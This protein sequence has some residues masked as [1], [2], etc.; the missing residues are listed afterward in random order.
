MPHRCLADF[1]E[2]LAADGQLAR[3]SAEVDSELEIAEITRRV[4][5]HGGPALLFEH[6]RGQSVAVV[7]NLL[8]TNGRACRALGI[9][10][11]DDIGGRIQALIE[12][13]TP[14]NWFDRL[15]MTGE[16]TGLQKFRAKLV[17]AG[18]CQ[19]V[20]RLGRDID[21]AV[22]P[23]VKAW[24]SES[25]ATITAG[26]II[27]Q[28]RAAEGAGITWCPLVAVDAQRLAVVNDGSSA[29]AHHQ[30]SY[31]AAGEKMPLVIVLGGAPAM[32][33]AAQLELP[34]GADAFQAIGLV[35]AA[36]LEIVK[37]RTHDLLVPSDADLVLEGYWDPQSEPVVLSTAAP[38]GNHYRAA[39]PLPVIQL[40]AITH[41]THPL[42]PALIEG[43]DGERQVLSLIRERTLLSAVRALAPDV[44]DLHLPL[45]G[46]TD[47]FAVASLKK[48]HPYHAR[49]VAAALWSL[50]TVGRAK[51]LI[52]VD[53]E[54]DV[55]DLQ[56]VWA[57]AGA[58]SAPERDLFWHDGPANTADHANTLGLLGRHVAID[59]TTKIAGECPAP[60]PAALV[61]S[62]ESRDLVT[63]RWAEYKLDLVRAGA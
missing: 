58:H 29:F 55:H 44:V 41:R 35:R 31:C 63:A 3:I 13:S 23:L 27:T 28:D 11:L 17:K 42:W 10:S 59:A 48:R 2:Q 36:P 45:L 18:P 15:R 4:A 43:E 30:A 26:L 6:V 47:R 7:T 39:T 20:V 16:E 1:L 21:L 54:I 9:D 25:A 8:G 14:Q 40:A 24:P 53:A 49:Q 50:S 52:L 46:G 56:Q 61:A 12:R 22:L 5:K 60:H 19:Q 34:S 32:L 62:Q 57:A 38:G 37:C 51:F 33:L